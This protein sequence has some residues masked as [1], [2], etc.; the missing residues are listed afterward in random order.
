MT[1]EDRFNALVEE[2]A[3]TPGVTPPGQAGSRGFGSSALKVNGSIFAMLTRDQLVVKLPRPRV[4]ALVHG[5][6]GYPFTAGKARPMKEWLAVVGNDDHTWRSLAQEA[7]KFVSS[8]H[9]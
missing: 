2:F 8:R 6:V 9:T 1:P 3:S 5:G 4:D 7:L